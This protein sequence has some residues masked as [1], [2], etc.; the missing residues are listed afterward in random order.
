[1][2][3]VELINQIRNVYNYFSSIKKFSDLVPE[4]RTNISGSI[5]NPNSNNDI[6][7]IEGRITIIGEFPKASGDIKFGVSDHTAR[8]ILTA[9]EF[10][11]DINFV[12]NLKYSPELINK[13][14]LES[15]LLIREI[16]RSDQPKKIQNKDFS[17]M[18]WIIRKCIEDTGNIPD[19][20]WDSGALGKEPMIRLFA[21]SSNKMISKLELILKMLLSL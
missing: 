13:L 8:L 4:V 14:Q 15:D 7:A 11:S 1:M 21:K 10:D 9:K 20:I 5:Q 19:I 6:A 16:S 12:M 18:Q 2:E 17:T 3:K